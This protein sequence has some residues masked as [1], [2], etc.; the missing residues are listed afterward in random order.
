MENPLKIL[1]TDILTLMINIIFLTYYS[2]IM[3][4]SCHQ[5]FLSSIYSDDRSPLIN[6]EH[7][8]KKIP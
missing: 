7:E 4:V 2:Y 8:V 3:S 5:V 6:I 1:E